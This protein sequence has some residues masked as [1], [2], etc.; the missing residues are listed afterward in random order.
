MSA[1]SRSR[2]WLDGIRSFWRGEKSLRDPS[3]VSLFNGGPVSAGVPVNEWTALNY[4]AFYGAIQVIAGDLSTLPVHVFQRD[5]ERRTPV[6]D[7]KLAWTLGT[8]A[9]P[10]MSSAQLLETVTAHALSWGNG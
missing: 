8:S 4:S 7:S 10:E 5:G 6:R 1:P 9:N 2:R 3:L